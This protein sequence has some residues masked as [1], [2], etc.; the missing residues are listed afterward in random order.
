MDMVTVKVP[1]L[2]G[3]NPCS[4]ALLIKTDWKNERKVEEPKEMSKGKRQEPVRYTVAD[5]TK[6]EF[7]RFFDVSSSGSSLRP[8][9]ERWLNEERVRD[10][11]SK[12]N[13]I[14]EKSNK[15]LNKYI[16]CVQRA[17]AEDDIEKKIAILSEGNREYELYEKAEE[18]YK[19]L[20]ARMDKLCGEGGGKK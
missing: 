3:A 15:Q 4:I 6:E 5:A 8:F 14:I 18:E 16:S 11:S 1:A 20:S 19:R 9:F 12:L 13:E 17:N 2:H 10:L 7:Q